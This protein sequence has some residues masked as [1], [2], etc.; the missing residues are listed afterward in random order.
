MN[1]VRESLQS[2]ETD[3]GKCIQVLKN[4]ALSWKGIERRALKETF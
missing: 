4:A 3:L 2:L 1:V